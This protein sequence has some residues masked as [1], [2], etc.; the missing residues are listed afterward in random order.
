MKKQLPIFLSIIF[1]SIISILFYL[2]SIER[3]PSNLPSALLNKNV[4]KFE[5][6]LLL[7]VQLV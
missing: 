4:P 3:N 5:T 7:K 1:F 6:E 2:L